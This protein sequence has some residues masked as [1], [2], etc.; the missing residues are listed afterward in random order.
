M[1]CALLLLAPGEC[2]IHRFFLFLLYLFPIHSASHP[3]NLRPH[4]HLLLPFLLELRRPSLHRATNGENLL[5]K[6]LAGAAALWFP[7]TGTGQSWSPL[8]SGAVGLEEEPVTVAEG[9]SEQPTTTTTPIPEGT[10]STRPRHQPEARAMQ[11]IWRRRR[12]A[13]V[14]AA[15][16]AIQETA[17][18]RGAL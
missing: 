14:A 2:H 3:S 6:L 4:H 5:E 11:Q 8:G 17:G 9:H 1:P 15:T 10:Y 7:R 13:G 16:A 12:G 18:G